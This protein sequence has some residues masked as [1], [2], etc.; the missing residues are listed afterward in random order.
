MISGPTSP[1]ESSDHSAPPRG[2]GSE[3]TP[4]E[5][6]GAVARRATTPPLSQ[7]PLSQ[8]PLS[9]PP[10]SQPPDN[11]GETMAESTP[12]AVEASALEA[13]YSAPAHD[14]GANGALPPVEPPVESP[15]E[16][17]AAPALP[18][19]AAP[20]PR[21]DELDIFEHLG[22]LRQRILYCVAATALALCATWNFGTQLTDWFSR[23]I[24]EELKRHGAI[25]MSGTLITIDPT[26]AFVV[27]FQIT[28]V[29][30]LLLVMPFILFQAWRFIEPALTRQ[31]RRYGLVMV[32]FSVVLFFVGAAL[33][34]LMS[35]VFFRF[36]LAFQ[37]PG[38]AAN[39]GYGKSA[40]LLAKML[41]VFGVCFQVPVITIL[42]HKIGLV[43]RNLLIEYWRHVVVVIFIVVAVITPTWDPFTLIVCALPPCILYA[44]SIWLVKWL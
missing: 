40:A 18:A 6:I 24:R 13:E 38:V 25:G 11:A 12:D 16:S 19:P 36:F 1:E 42:L 32:P 9:Q 26:E 41:L 5:A 14:S 21:S 44:L 2:A 34:Y 43:S 33:G 22:E 28:L 27:Y 15:V 30:A 8:P 17:P 10:L 35:P 37:P 23:P 39:F 29:A 3:I 7:P 4:R 31:E 20:R